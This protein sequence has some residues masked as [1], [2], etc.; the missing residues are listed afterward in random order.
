MRPLV[1][2]ARI[3]TLTS[4]TIEVGGALADF[5]SPHRNSTLQTLAP[6]CLASNQTRNI[7]HHSH[8]RTWL[9]PYCFVVLY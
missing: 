8:R 6:Y 5:G 1:C 3:V 4:Q 9:T 2:G 7:S